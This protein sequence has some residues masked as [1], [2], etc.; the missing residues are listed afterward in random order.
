[1]NEIKYIVEDVRNP[2]LDDGER[3]LICHCCNDLPAMGAGVARAL[4]EKWSQVRSEY[5]KWGK[6]GY[7]FELGNIQGVRVEENIAVIN[8][9]GQHDIKPQN[10]IPP[11]RYGAIR[12]CLKKVCKIAKKYDASVHIPYLVGCDLAGGNWEEMEKIIEQ[13]LCEN[14]IKV[15]AYDLFNKRNKKKEENKDDIII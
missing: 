2:E 13:E 5:M 14:G 8:M 12:R 15:I 11:I 7:N 3:G 6:H 1:M 9:I 4:F 10:G